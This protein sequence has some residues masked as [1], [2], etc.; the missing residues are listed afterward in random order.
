MNELYKSDTGEWCLYKYK[1]KYVQDGIQNEQYTDDK[2]WFET[3]ASIYDS[4]KIIEIIEITYRSEQIQRL[5]EIQNY[6]Y[7]HFDEL[8]DYVFNNKIKVDSEIFKDK[9]IKSAI[10]E[11]GKQVTN[12]LMGV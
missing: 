11:L 9:I 4:F 7:T 3:F 10:T 12:I 6:E 8:Y 1:I 2:A 5:T